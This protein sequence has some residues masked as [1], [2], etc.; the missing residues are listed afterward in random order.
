MATDKSTKSSTDEEG[1]EVTPDEGDATTD[2]EI[3]AVAGA[4]DT[5]IPAPTLVPRIGE[6]VLYVTDWGETL[7]ALVHAAYVDDRLDVQ[8]DGPD[9]HFAVSQVEHDVTLQ[10]GTW[11]WPSEEE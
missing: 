5:P 4:P 7:S 3:P 11:H 9:R 1:A 10:P 2:P 8:V 6:S